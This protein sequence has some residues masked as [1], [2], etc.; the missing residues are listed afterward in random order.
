[1]NTQGITSAGHVIQ[2]LST[3]G[4][5]HVRLPLRLH[6]VVDLPTSRCSCLS[7]QNSW[8]LGRRA[9]IELPTDNWSKGLANPFVSATWSKLNMAAN[10][11][12]I[13]RQRTH[14]LDITNKLNRYHSME[15][16]G[17]H[18]FFCTYNRRVIDSIK[19]L[20]L[21]FK[22]RLCAF[23]FIDHLFS[24][25]NDYTCVYLIVVKCSLN[26]QSLRQNE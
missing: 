17:T 6:G 26:K 16:F 3:M 1:M 9:Q 10:V 12:T 22:N 8:T 7:Q 13:H 2:F 11:I 15:L 19:K 21:I 20:D 24:K 25:E 4:H 5:V 18:R 14:F 23:R